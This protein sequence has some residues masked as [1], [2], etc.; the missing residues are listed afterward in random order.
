MYMAWVQQCHVDS[1]DFGRKKD[2]CLDPRLNIRGYVDV[3][4]QKK[5]DVKTMR[6]L[7]LQMGRQ[8]KP[9]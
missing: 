1:V 4:D 8:M 2:V 6:D 3:A 5:T 9:D 7:G